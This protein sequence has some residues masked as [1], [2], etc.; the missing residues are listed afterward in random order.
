MTSYFGTI[1]YVLMGIYVVIL[2]GIGFALKNKASESLSDYVIGGN[3][4]P[5]WA[6]G[7]SGM[8][9][10]LD[11]AGTA[12]IVSFL[13]LL[14]PRGLFIEFRGGAVLILVFMMLWTGKWHRRSGCMTNAEWNLFRFGDRWE[15]HFARILSVAG[16][17]FNNVSAM[18]YLIYGTGIFLAMFLPFEPW[19]CALVMIGAATLYT[20]MA[21]FYGVILTDLFQSS[22]IIIAVIAISFISFNMVTDSDIFYETAKR[23]SGNGEWSS[24][25][26]QWE[27]NMPEGYE[28]YTHLII[29]MTLYLM[30]NVFFGMGAGG[31][32]R[33]FGAKSDK[34]CGKLTFLWTLLMGVRWPMMMG[35]AVMGIFLVD[36][37][38][39]E[40]EMT[41]QAVAIIQTAY[42]E[43]T[44]KTWPNVVAQVANS[45]ETQDPAMMTQLRNLL[46]EEDWNQKIQ[47]LGFHGG[48]NPERILP[49]A[50]INSVGT[51]LRG[52]L[53][54]AFVA[55]SLSTFASFVNMTTGLVVNDLY[56]GYVR[57]KAKTKELIYISWVTVLALVGLAFWFSTTLSS[58]NEIWG[59]FIMGI[60]SALMV[61][62]T[63]RFYW[64][65][66]NG[67]GLAWG[68]LTGL[69]GA[70]L[71]RIFF[72][73]LNE[74]QTL[75]VALASGFSG[76]IIGTYFSRPTD[77]KVLINFYRKTRP[78]GFW[79]PL[80]DSLN[81]K[82]RIV[83]RNEHF[84]D[85]IS[86]PFALV[87]QV[88]MFLAPM[89]F[90]I[91]NFDGFWAV[92]SITLVGLG[93]LWYFW[94]RHMDKAEKEN[95]IFDEPSEDPEAS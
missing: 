77:P 72:P 78:F 28:A 32:P 20:M 38:Y 29:I 79:G 22:I 17:F 92:T 51:G 47:L 73:E 84:R 36:S 64:W 9:Q 19:Q 23:V 56:L 66:F 5:W 25:Y 33:Y 41:E 8:A 26:P 83:V 57:P 60:G 93:G 11:L 40:P 39:P 27:T 13:F 85:L 58:I 10:F 14:G 52:L 24:W 55:A 62:I 86:V 2:L 46:G 89:L 37:F 1:D 90:I 21:G 7:V 16:G 74:F 61:P 6:M 48:V 43:A 53:V 35:L 49:A 3:K 82:E 91:H 63:L 44:D 31:E 42:P 34:E 15:A 76:C 88:G 45:P 75:G 81:D 54:I 94:L 67:G 71:Q 59:W 69:S 70:I 95:E 12:L 65:R 80:K 30:R 50:L 4:L 87:F 68:T 18:A